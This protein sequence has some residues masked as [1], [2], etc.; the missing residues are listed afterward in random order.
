MGVQVETISPGDGRTFPKRG[1]TWMLEDGKKFDSSRDRNKPFK[2]MLGKQE[3]IRGWEEG[4]A[5]MSVGQR[6]KLT[7][8]PDYAYGATGHPGIIPP[9][10]TLVFDVELLKLE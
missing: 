1:Q 8:S 3:V 9:H 10:A 4:V 2:F 6:A 7:I 5:Q